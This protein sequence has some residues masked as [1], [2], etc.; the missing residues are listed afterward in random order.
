MENQI[1][2]DE[3]L[4]EFLLSVP[5]FAAEAT[6]QLHNNDVNVL[7]YYSAKCEEYCKIVNILTYAAHQFSEE[8]RE[9]HATAVDQEV[10]QLY[11]KLLQQV[12]ALRNEFKTKAENI[13]TDTHRHRHTQFSWVCWTS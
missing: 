6:T 12:L 9:D 2:V 10:F 7:E 13:W 5:R 3:H 11:S 1:I 4:S 8:A